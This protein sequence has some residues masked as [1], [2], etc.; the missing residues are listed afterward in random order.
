MY[1]KGKRIFIVED[2]AAN[3][4]IM[5]VTMEQ[6][7]ARTMFERWGVDTIDRLNKAMPV[8]VIIMDMMLPD[9]MTGFEVVKR[10]RSYPEFADIP[11]VA[12]SAGDANTLA[13]RAQAEGFAGFIAK[14]IDY[15]DFPKQIAQILNR[16]FAFLKA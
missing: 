14:P 6:H 10:I 12:V 16:E 1:L 3:L 13:P 11:V 7:G 5:Q 9:N 2:N 15:D 4:L 8:D